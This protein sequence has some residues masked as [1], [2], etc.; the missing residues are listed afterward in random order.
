M[1][2][3]PFKAYLSKN[4][5]SCTRLPRAFRASNNL[6]PVPENEGCPR[7]QKPLGPRENSAFSESLRMA[8]RSRTRRAALAARFRSYMGFN[9]L[10]DNGVWDPLGPNFGMCEWLTPRGD[11]ELGPRLGIILYSVLVHAGR[12]VVIPACMHV[13]YA[14]Q[15]RMYIQL[16]EAL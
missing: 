9:G 12:C 10:Q 7:P 8:F 6:L 11:T 14:G 3:E 5:T 2:V 13:R 1:E 4:R 15:C 16:V